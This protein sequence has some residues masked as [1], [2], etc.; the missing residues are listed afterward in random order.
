MTVLGEGSQGI[1]YLKDKFA[2]KKTITNNEDIK[3][4]YQHLININQRLLD[5]PNIVK[6]HNFYNDSY[7]MEY[8]EGYK[9]LENTFIESLTLEQKNSI[10]NQVYK[11]MDDLHG[12]NYVHGDL[13]ML[14]NI[15]Y[16]ETLDKI[17]L[18]DCGYCK[19][20]NRADTKNALELIRRDYK[21]LWALKAKLKVQDF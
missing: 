2:I 9:E 12:I 8:L 1:V 7:S 18:I 13:R 5:H 20:L 4:E 3:R 19:N 21:H 15:M 6:V 14:K 10:F 11:T 16:N 17:K